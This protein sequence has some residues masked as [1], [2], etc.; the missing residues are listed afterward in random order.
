MSQKRPRRLRA[1][2]ALRARRPPVGS[3]P[4]TL[5]TSGGQTWPTVVSYIG[6][7]AHVLTEHKVAEL[8]D[9][10]GLMGAH[11]VNWIDVEGFADREKL[12][13]IAGALGLHPL[14]LEDIVHADQRPKLE[15]HDDYLFIVARMANPDPDGTALTEQIAIIVGDGWIVTFQER[16]GDCL[17]PVRRRLREGRGRIRG[18]A[19]TYLAYALVDAVIDS[20]FPLLEDFG[21]TVERLEERMLA[22][23]G[24]GTI[25][26]VHRV[27]RELLEMRRAIWPHRE[28]VGAMLREEV[29][30]ADPGL[31]SYLRDCQDHAIQLMDIVE[32]YREISM[33]L[34]DLYMSGTSARLNE[35]MKVL[36]IIATIFM[37]LSFIAGVYGMNFDRSASPWNMPEL[38]WAWGYAFALALMAAVA[39][40][41]LF[42]FRRRGWLGGSDREP[43]E[44]EAGPSAPSHRGNAGR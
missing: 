5:A 35:V 10:H 16:P 27:K 18:S 42:W 40:G 37:P 43:P 9:V 13:T 3:A 33:G 29:F 31:A 14:V 30:L 39:G 20:Y 19:A 34:V 41:L 21:E 38:G 26:G 8:A 4:G 17:E 1:R 12:A 44:D 24:R 7:D 22:Q 6:Y 25:A 15:V 28:M 11:I 23:P 36:T 2:L 32:T